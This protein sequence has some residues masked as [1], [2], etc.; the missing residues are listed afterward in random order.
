MAFGILTHLSPTLTLLVLL[1]SLLLWLFSRWSQLQHIPGPVFASFSNLPRLLWARTARYHEIQIDLH[2][3][4][5]KL[6]RLGPNCVSVGDP[7][8][9]SKIYGT[10]AGMLKVRFTPFEKKK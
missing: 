3:K 6:V 9:I 2:K 7:Q 10:G 4:Y 1:I 5:G 8:E